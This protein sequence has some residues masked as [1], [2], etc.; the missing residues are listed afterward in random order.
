MSSNMTA[1]VCM[2]RK[3]FYLISAHTCAIVFLEILRKLL[4]IDL[5]IR[6]ERRATMAKSTCVGC[7]ISSR[8]KVLNKENNSFCFLFFS[9]V[10][11][12]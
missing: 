9:I 2:I 10:S 8:P 3:I 1:F 6:Q 12:K 5:N 7:L 11:L 4:K